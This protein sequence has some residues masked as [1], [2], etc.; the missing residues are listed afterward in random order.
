MRSV[1]LLAATA[2]I[3]GLKCQGFLTFLRAWRIIIRTVR[4]HRSVGGPGF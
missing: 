4:T 3:Q 1:A 2:P